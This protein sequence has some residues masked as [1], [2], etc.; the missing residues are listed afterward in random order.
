[1]SGCLATPCASRRCTTTWRRRAVALRV[2]V[3]QGC[4]CMYYGLLG[5]CA[6]NT[7]FALFRRMFAYAHVHGKAG[8]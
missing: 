8:Y 4:V 3:L 2:H 1:M 7:G 6:N 5:C